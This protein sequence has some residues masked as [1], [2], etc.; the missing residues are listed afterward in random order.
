MEKSV[1]KLILVGFAYILPYA[2]YYSSYCGL[3]Q[4]RLKQVCLLQFFDFAG[5]CNSAEP[6]QLR[7]LI[8]DMAFFWNLRWSRQRSAPQLEERIALFVWRL[9]G[10]VFDL[11]IASEVV[12]INAASSPLDSHEKQAYW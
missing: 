11:E 4:Q 2:F 7:L 1:R 9:M 5:S 8:K 12:W 6:D 3:F 10:I